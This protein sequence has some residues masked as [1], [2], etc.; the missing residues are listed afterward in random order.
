MPDTNAIHG[1][2][3]IDLVATSPDCIRLSQ[4]M[5]LVSE[6]YGKSV[7]FHTSSSSSMDLDDRNAAG[8]ALRRRRQEA[9]CARAV[10][11]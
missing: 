11:F 8:D 4:M 10:S 2:D 3:I 1:H 9:A 5:E 6:R 7:T